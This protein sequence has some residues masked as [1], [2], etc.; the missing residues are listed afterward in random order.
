M[1]NTFTFLDADVCNVKNNK[2]KT[3]I[4][5]NVKQKL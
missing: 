3:F 4:N 2:T 5:D 1:Y